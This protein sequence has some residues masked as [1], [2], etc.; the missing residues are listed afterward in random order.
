MLRSRTDATQL[1]DVAY[2]HVLSVIFC[3]LESTIP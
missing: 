1:F 3:P 2:Q